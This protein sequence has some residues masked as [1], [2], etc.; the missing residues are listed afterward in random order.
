MAAASTLLYNEI[1]AHLKL[2]SPALHYEIAAAAGK[3]PMV[4]QTVSTALAVDTLMEAYYASSPV[5]DAGHLSD[6]RL[7]T[8]ENPLVGT[9]ED[10]TEFNTL[11]TNIGVRLTEF[12]DDLE[13]ESEATYH[14]GTYDLIRCVSV[15]YDRGFLQLRNGGVACVRAC[16]L[17]RRRTL[18]PVHSVAF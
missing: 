18:L 1:M 2:S 3:N 7:A 10:F 16:C 8:W 13:A 6:Y 9:P 4:T 15:A 17:R 12:D 5:E 14:Y 11:Y